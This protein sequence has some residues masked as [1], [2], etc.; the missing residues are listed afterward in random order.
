MQHY[1]NQLL[2]DINEELGKINYYLDLYVTGGSAMSFYA[3]DND[4]EG[5][6]STRD[7]DYVNV[8][9]N[10]NLR[11][12]LYEFE[13][14]FAGQFVDA[15]PIEDY[16]T[17]S[18]LYSFSKELSHL[19]VYIPKL[20]IVFV[21]KAMSTR[22]K[23]LEDCYFLKDFVNLDNCEDMLKELITYQAYINPDCNILNLQRD[24][25]INKLL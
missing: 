10:D 24:N 14:E 12:L 9:A 21:N 4:I 6:R 2:L 13:T 23:D 11:D 5:M 15:V 18:T 19:N 1:L 7:I 3:I 17:N 20:E 16:Y 25:I 22:Q 8:I